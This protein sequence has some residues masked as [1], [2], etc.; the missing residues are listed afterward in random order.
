MSASFMSDPTCPLSTTRFLVGD[1]T[2]A[3]EL[4]C[5]DHV[6]S[7]RSIEYRRQA[8]IGQLVLFLYARNVSS[9]SE[10][11]GMAV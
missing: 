4:N 3:T 5:P 8:G 9:P 6:Q 2:M 1:H 11:T 10:G 7:L